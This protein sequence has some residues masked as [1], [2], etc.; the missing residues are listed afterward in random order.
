MGLNCGNRG[1]GGL[2]DPCTTKTTWPNPGSFPHE[3]PFG[4]H[5]N[6]KPSKQRLLFY[7][8]IGH[9]LSLGF[10]PWDFLLV[11]RKIYRF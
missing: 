2:S 6:L 3:V 5:C 9:M 11:E 1:Q 7:L 8:R 4:E 10:Q